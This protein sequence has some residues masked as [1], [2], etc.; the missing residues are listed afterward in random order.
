MTK[1]NAVRILEEL[2]IA[3]ELKA[4]EV[5]EKDLSAQTVAHKVGMPLEQVYKTLVAKGDRGG[6]VLAVIAADRALDLKALA[7]ATGDRSVALIPLK[8]VQPLTGY[9]R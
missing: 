3:F 4:Y 2:G 5:D 7:R 8:D 9:I 6:V 1:T